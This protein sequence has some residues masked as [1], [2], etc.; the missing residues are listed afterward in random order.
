MRSVAP[1]NKKL[2]DMGTTQRLTSRT[3]DLIVEVEKKISSI[4]DTNSSIL[5]AEWLARFL[6]SNY[7]GIY[8]LARVE[9]ALVSRFDLLTF[10]G[11]RKPVLHVASELYAHGGHTRLMKNLI[12]AVDSS[13]SQTAITRAAQPDEIAQLLEISPDK[14]KV[15]AESEEAKKVVA[16]AMY[17]VQFERLVLHLHPDDVTAAVAIGLAKKSSPGLKVFFVNHSDHTFSSAIAS[18]DRVLE[19]SAYGLSLAEARGVTKRCSFIGIPISPASANENGVRADRVVLTGGS[20]Y[21]FKPDEQRSLPSA[22]SALLRADKNVSIVAIGPRTADYWW[23]PLKLRF[24]GRFRSIGRVPYAEYVRLLSS[25]SLYVDSYPVTGGTAFTE[26]LMG[27]ANV[28]GRTGGPNGYGLADKLRRTGE[29][30]FVEHCLSL[31]NNDSFAL[32]EQEKIRKH[33]ATF[34]SLEALK[35]R[36]LTTLFE[37]A[38]HAPP[39]AMRVSEFS[40]DFRSQWIQRGR[41]V[42][43]GFRTKAQIHLLPELFSL[44]MKAGADP[45]FILGV[46][47]RAAVAWLRLRGSRAAR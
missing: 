36:F 15:F 14:V 37:D 20:A 21:K 17:F 30:L 33:A 46:F 16:L 5:L 3:S 43:V 32:L 44:F 12:G 40:Y 11:Q 47:L 38:V 31:L 18:A 1:A 42:A 41:M 25:C 24:P 45:R 34:H 19:I 7:C 23:W 28:S 39:L 29:S 22:F 6:C 4:F 9:E 27:G 13:M 10:A 26:A 35:Q 2:K 8:T